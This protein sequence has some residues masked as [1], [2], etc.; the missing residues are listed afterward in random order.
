MHRAWYLLRTQ[1]MPA[2]CLLKLPW[3]SC[4]KKIWRQLSRVRKFSYRSLTKT[5]VKSKCLQEPDRLPKGKKQARCEAN[6]ERD[7]ENISFAF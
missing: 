7:L 3:L 4:R 6:P 1:E 5:R 2:P